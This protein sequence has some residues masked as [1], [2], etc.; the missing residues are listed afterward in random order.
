MA[1]ICSLQGQDVQI[2]RISIHMD[3]AALG[4]ILDE[5]EKQSGLSFS[6][7]SR[8]LDEQEVHTLHV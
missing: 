5:I 6:Y 4:Q 8:L 2:R 1:S 7:N 3:E